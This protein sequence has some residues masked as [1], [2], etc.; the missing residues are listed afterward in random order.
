M[1]KIICDV[2]GYEY[3]ETEA[4]CPLCGCA[5]KDAAKVAAPVANE[6][7]TPADNHV[8]G[9]RFSNGNVR[10]RSKTG[11][12][13]MVYSAAKEQEEDEEEQVADQE[14]PASNRPMMI[15]VILLLLAIIAVSTYIAILFSDK[16]EATQNSQPTS[17]QLPDDKTVACKDFT[18]NNVENS[19]VVFNNSGEIL[20]L[21]CTRS[22]E[23]C[24]EPFYYSSS[25]T[26]VAVVNLNGRIEARGQ[27]T[28]TIT[29]KCGQVMKQIQVICNFD[30]SID[31]PGQSTKPIEP[32]A[33]TLPQDSPFTIPSGAE[34]VNPYKIVIT[35]SGESG[36]NVRK[37]PGTSFD[38]VG[39]AYHNEELTVIAICDDATRE[40][41]WVLTEKGWVTMEYAEV[42]G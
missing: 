31:V 26:G 19:V 4:Q 21:D 9:G 42:I 27:G 7:Q 32:T 1:E 11:Y 35:Y 8:K 5:K 15:V 13:P 29:I 36:V 23:D 41:P 20:E 28:T 17:S 40:W 33:P 37:G 25:D 6:T 34:A 10:K 30:G 39:K 18:L 24:R 3:S 14:K 12:M 22:P 16:G 38:K 2:C